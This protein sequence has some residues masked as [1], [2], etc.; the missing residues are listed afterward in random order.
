[1]VF[2]KSRFLRIFPGLAVVLLF[3]VF[4][5]GP[6]VTTL[7]LSDYFTNRQTYVYLKAILLY[8]MQ[9]NLPGV[10]ENNIYKGAV[11]GSLWTI[12]FEV[13][14]YAIVLILG[15]FKLLRYKKVVL[16]IFVINIFVYLFYSSIF[17]SGKEQILGLQFKDFIGLFMYFSA[18]MLIY[19]YRDHIIINKYYAMIAV[20]ILF[21]AL[22]YGGLKELF[23]IFGSYLVFYIAYESRIKLQNFSKYGDFS[24]GL[25]IYAFPIQ[26]LVT[27]Y[28]GG[29]MKATTNF[30][31][32]FFASLLLAF[33]SWHLIEKNAL[34]LKKI[35]IIDKLIPNKRML[36]SSQFVISV[37]RIYSTLL[38]RSIKIG[39]L[40]FLILLLV[41]WGGLYYYNDK[42]SFIEFP[43]NKSSSI[44]YEGWQPQ[45][46]D[47]KYRWISASAGVLMKKPANAEKLYIV[48][49]VPEGF[50]EVK[51]MSVYID[52]IKIFESSLNSGQSINAEIVIKS[53]YQGINKIVNIKIEFDG[54]HVPLKDSLDQRH[55]S[56]LINK[57]YFK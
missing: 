14:C 22:N 15:I 25:Y 5:L 48:G 52:E 33:F 28:F 47:E 21:L 27:Y 18:G 53:F 10:F 51:K 23:T 8:P 19:A 35:S 55:L 7:S 41:F 49:Y 24:Y 56:A 44:F 4:L 11:N 29:V 37:S 30:I 40:K 6:L 39:W 34:K 31:I 46:R 26:Q 38:D 45:E 50:T 3:S 54:V 1:M 17:P 42:P 13:L 16:L 32:S 9:W 12:P 43:Y 20:F 57:I 2:I 36:I